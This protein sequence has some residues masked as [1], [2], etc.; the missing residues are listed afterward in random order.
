M[1][2][3]TDVFAQFDSFDQ[4]IFLP[5]V[6]EDPLRLY[7][8]HGDSFDSALDAG[9]AEQALEAFADQNFE[10][11][12]ATEAL[13]LIDLIDPNKP[14]SEELSREGISFLRSLSQEVLE[15][16]EA[17]SPGAR[18]SLELILKDMPREV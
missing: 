15:C 18:A 13:N 6:R 1:T 16:M 11:P 14:L 17:L 3:V 10:I 9:V 12:E 2:Q 8:D 4:S 5:S 7:N